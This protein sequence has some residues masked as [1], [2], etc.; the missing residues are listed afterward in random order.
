[1]TAPVTRKVRIVRA[2]QRAML[3]LAP[4]EV[5]QR[6]RTEMI[7]T[8]E[9]A[10]A[11]AGARSTAALCGLLIRE[12]IDLLAARRA[13][14]PAG[15]P[16]PPPSH[17][18]HAVRLSGIGM[19]EPSS[20]RQAFRSLRR[21]PAFLIASVLTLGFGSGVTTAVFSLVDTV[22]IKPLP[23]PDAD[24]LV[25]VYEFSPA[26]RERRSLVAPARLADWNRLSRSFVVIAGSYSE[27]V[28]DTSAAEPERLAGVR[29][30]PRFFDV[31]AAPP[32]AGRPFTDEEEREN[33]PG[34]AVISERLWTRRFHRDPSALGRALMIGGRPYQ[35]VGVMPATFTAAA[36][37]VWLPAQHGAFL[38]RMREARFHNGVGRLRPGV[39]VEEGARE[40]ASVQEALGREFPK[41]DADWSVE[42]RPLKD[43]RVGTKRRGLLLI[44][45]AVVSLWLIA[46][47]NI[48]GLTLVQV[49]R[50]ARELAVRAALGASRSAVIGTVIREGA[51]IGLFGS[52][53]GAGLA[54]L[55]VGVMPA[56]L[57][58]TPRINELVLDWRALLFTVATSLAATCG[59]SVIPA[60]AG[61][62]AGLNEV[63]AAGARGVAGGRHRFQQALV[64]CQV[65]LSILLVGAA[66]LLLR[67]Y[68]N[69]TRVETGF[70]ASNVVTFH[71]GARWDEDRARV[72]TLQTQL[73]ERVEQRPH[74]Q[75]AGMTNFLPAAGATLRYQVRVEGLTGP[76]ADG[77]ITVGIR[78]I[79]G[80][81]LRAIRAELTAGTW[82]PAATLDAKAPRAVMVNRRFVDQH[83]ANQNVVGRQLNQREAGGP[84][85]IA[86][87]I[88]DVTEDGPASSSVPYV[89]VCTAAGWWP[90]PEYVART[91]DVRAFAA[92]L[93]Q[94]VRELDSSRAIFGMRPLSDV[95]EAAL[96]QPRLDAAMLGSF[97]GAALT[98]AAVGLYSLFMLIVAERAREIAVR[99]AIGAAPREMIRLVMA[100]AGRLLG[101]GIVLGLGLTAAADRLLR[102]VLFGVSSFDA[103]ALAVSALV[104]AI[105][106]ALAVAGPAIKAARI[107]PI[108]AL[109]AD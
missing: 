64:I 43:V 98:L 94:I 75:A 83:A 65:A 56:L 23:Y 44:F 12:A 38:L 80:G 67:S 26:A 22:L 97:A 69:L 24:R 104:L 52:A 47:A 103:P 6:Y 101:I 13:N 73:L 87:V 109:R 77:S 17:A 55:L 48:A 78:M 50:R 58:A 66:T 61:T 95:L 46:V 42:V 36:T 39:S 89:Y 92:D 18:E 28:T 70:D 79:S 10:S 9:A 31:Y 82:C 108:D 8:F 93:R 7:A 32:L 21:R 102:G 85:T 16:F 99:L 41:T 15:V 72:A 29:V 54:T 37:D 49:R 20:W 86:G 3:P 74:V 53:V 71:V 84:A 105:V 76:N 68:Y 107:A 60:F 90:D 45:G 63:M 34:A 27:N 106:S 2:L 1:M 57:S 100:G 4:R 96:G 5:R 88:A 81:Y 40:I 30:S 14:R 91:T 35:I 19:I 62:R 25:T 11:D 33:G 59:F 51:I